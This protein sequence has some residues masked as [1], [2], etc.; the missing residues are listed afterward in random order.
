MFQISLAA[1]IFKIAPDINKILQLYID[2][3]ETG[4]SEI[5]KAQ[6]T[7]KNSFKNQTTNFII[8]I[9]DILTKMA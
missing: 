6:S 1:R 5:D 9:N 7:L 4:S 8:Y 2:M 3:H